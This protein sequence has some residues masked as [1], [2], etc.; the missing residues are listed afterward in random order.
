M[1]LPPFFLQHSKQKKNILLLF[2]I[3]LFFSFSDDAI[4]KTFP[5][6]PCQYKETEQTM[7]ARMIQCKMWRK[8]VKK[9]LEGYATVEEIGRQESK[10]TH[11]TISQISSVAKD[12]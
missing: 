4:S 2:I 1:L 5:M 12:E 10:L 9:A 7:R 6:E 11:V 3:I 8:H